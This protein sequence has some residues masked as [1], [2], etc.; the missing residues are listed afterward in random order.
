MALQVQWE[1]WM[2]LQSKSIGKIKNETIICCRLYECL[3]CN[4][5]YEMYKGKESLIATKYSK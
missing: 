2:N 1:K 5:Q 3:H 4:K